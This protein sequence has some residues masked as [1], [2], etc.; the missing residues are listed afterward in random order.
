MGSPKKIRKK[1]ETPEHPWRKERI[2]AEKLLVEEYGL[3]NKTEVYK[4]SSD[5]RSYYRQA[6]SL[7]SSTSVQSKKEE[8]QFLEKLYSLNLIQDRNMKV[9]NVLNL[10][11]KDLMERRLQ[12]LILKKGMAKSIMQAR[13]FIIHGHVF[14]GGKK[15]TVPSYL[16]RRN[17]ENQIIYDPVSTLSSADHP[18]R[19][20]MMA[21][22]TKEKVSLA[23]QSAAEVKEEHKQ[24]VEH[25]EA[26]KEVKK[27]KPKKETKKKDKEE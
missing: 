2:D 3:K 4:I 14:V 17:E 24:H 7:I 23:K 27:D 21:K 12:T 11:I 1:Y 18:E 19:V 10:N 16:V 20:K 26:K 25:K 22:E 15:M 6:R 8:K 9:E 13:Q 5:L